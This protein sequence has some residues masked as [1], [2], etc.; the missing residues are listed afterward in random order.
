MEI[1]SMPSRQTTQ[2]GPANDI[3]WKQLWSLAALYASVIIGWIAYK[4]YQ[5]RLLV[6]FEFTDFTFALMV[7]QG[8]ILTITPLI[9][10]RLG[11]RHRF[12]KGHR[13]PIISAGISFAAMVFMAVAFTLLGNPG[14]I[15]RWLLPVLIVLWLVGMSIFTSP[16]LS[17]MEL[18]TP[19]EKLP[20]AMAVL[21][22]VGSLVYSLE[23][24]IV[25]IIDYLG[26]PITF[27]LGGTV[28]LLSGYGLKKTSLV[29][30]KANENRE[31]SSVDK[32]NRQSPYGFIFSLGLA[33]GLA[34]TMLFYLFPPVFL[35]KVGKLLEVDGN[36]AV[37]GTLFLSALISW[38]VCDAVNRYGMLRMFRVSVAVIV[39][40]SLGIYFSTPAGLVLAFMV[41][42]AISFACLSISALPLAIK[43][44][45]F[46][47]KVFCVGIFF[48]AAALPEGI[49]EAYLA[50][51]QG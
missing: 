45:A 43:R 5:P 23:P 33:T 7:G 12:E 27:M 39:F 44:A 20:R 9:A 32:K 29:L 31:P 35:S 28:V 10:G 41:L 26:A 18:F 37:A 25:D 22:I 13:L 30:F 1:V 47:E 51:V 3:C 36:M 15:F 4:N 49:W 21:T 8:L 38:P 14:E 24:L 48:G 17:T 2:T 42:F 16:A 6:Q 34:T 50:W 19:V 11:D 40:S 46:R